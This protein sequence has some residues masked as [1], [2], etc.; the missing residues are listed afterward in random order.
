MEGDQ[1]VLLNCRN[2][3][4]KVTPEDA[5]LVPHNLQ[6]MFTR[7][8]AAAYDPNIGCDVFERVVSEALLDEKDQQLFLSYAAYV[9]QPNCK[10]HAALV[11]HGLGGTGKSTVWDAVSAVM[12]TDLVMNVSLR[13]LCAGNGY[14]IPRLRFAALNVGTEAPSGELAESD[15]LKMLVCGEPVEARAIYGRPEKL[16]GYSVK[17]VFLSNH[18][19]RFKSGTDAE[20][21]RLR[22]LQFDRKPDKID[23]LLAPK[24][25]AEKDGIFSNIM[26]PCLRGLLAT[27][28]IPE[29][30]EAS[31]AAKKRFALEN[32]PMESFVAECCVLGPDIYEPKERLHRAFV[33]WARDKDVALGLQTSE[34]F[35]RH[36]RSRR[37]GLGDY[38]PK[39]DGQRRHCLRG[40]RLKEGVPLVEEYELDEVGRRRRGGRINVDMV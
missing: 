38:R 22:F 8:I 29:G 35:F 25:A 36:L 32:D 39:V 37:T 3:V 16:E 40:V 18:L 30:G 20:L 34:H 21:R 14:S 23:P 2:G 31:R 10:L 13:Q 33:A 7:Q 1:T 5:V 19:P 24:L 11:C 6:H 4:L 27:P 17:F 9:L 12:G 28:V 15:M 26:V